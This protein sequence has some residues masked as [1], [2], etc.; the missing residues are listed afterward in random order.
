MAD[1]PYIS[2]GTSPTAAHWRTL[3]QELEHKMRFHYEE[4]GAPFWID[5]RFLPNKK[6]YVL[7]ST[8]IKSI[9]NGDVFNSMAEYIIADCAEGGLLN[10]S[11]PNDWFFDQPTMEAALDA[12]QASL[13]L[14]NCP[15]AGDPRPRTSS[16]G[17]TLLYNQS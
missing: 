10:T 4:T 3:F 2:P 15:K 13:T 7:G 11:E 17:P 1:V 9:I 6:S 12:V 8:P 16:L 14:A 5:R